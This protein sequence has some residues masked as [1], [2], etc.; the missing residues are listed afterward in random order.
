MNVATMNVA[1][2]FGGGTVS[3][4]YVAASIYGFLLLVLAV[5]TVL[6]LQGVFD[7]R[8][9]VEAQGDMLLRL[10]GRGPA[11]AGVA[12]G[13]SAM[14]GSPVLEG[15]TVT[16]AGAALLE[17]VVATVTRHGGSVLS[18]QVDLQGAQAKDGFLS[19]IA[20]CDLEQPALQAIVYDLE[21]GMPFLFVDQL[22]VQAPTSTG[23]AGGKLRVL[24][25]VSGQWQGAP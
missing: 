24:I 7:R 11:A 14:V 19:V 13:A 21:A 8:A 17:R 3:P 9:A 12:T 20:S 4:P 25:S 23:T 15:A 10:E 6:P 1:R 18:S 16:V 2:M 22:V 5:A